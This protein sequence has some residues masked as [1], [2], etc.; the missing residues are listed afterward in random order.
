VTIKARVTFTPDGG[1]AAMQTK[2]LKVK[3]KKKKH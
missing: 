1:T 3:G 2:K